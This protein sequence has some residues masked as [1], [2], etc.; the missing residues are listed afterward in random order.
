MYSLI[1][2]KL[3]NINQKIIT[4]IHTC[5]C[6]SIYMCF[7]SKIHVPISFGKV[8]NAKMTGNPNTLPVILLNPISRF[9]NINCIL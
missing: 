1:V 2:Q 3:K 9:F 5:I 6:T 8:T 4:T 7:I